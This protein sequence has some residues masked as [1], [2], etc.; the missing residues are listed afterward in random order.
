MNN[1]GIIIVSCLL[2]VGCTSSSSRH[3][4]PPLMRLDPEI[5][6]QPRVVESSELTL[7]RLQAMLHARYS[8]T[9]MLTEV[10]DASAIESIPEED[11][12]L[13][14]HQGLSPAVIAAITDKQAR[15]QQNQQAEQ[16][17][18]QLRTQKLEQA[19][20]DRLLRIER[21]RNLDWGCGLYP[22]LYPCAP[23]G[24]P[25]YWGHPA[26]FGIGLGWGSRYWW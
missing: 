17:L 18:Q 12:T 14:K 20:Q 10:Q 22:T 7:E 13:L 16:L 8:E 11:L 4:A 19:R 1:F 5:A 23:W 6:I 2:L 21:N 9:E 25:G 15:I 3:T 24:Y 26:R